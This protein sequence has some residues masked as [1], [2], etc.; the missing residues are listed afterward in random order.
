M[1]VAP[2]KAIADNQPRHT[3]VKNSLDIAAASFSV[4]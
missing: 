3:A 1:P 2:Q 4:R